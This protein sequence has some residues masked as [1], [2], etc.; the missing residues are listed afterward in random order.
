MYCLEDW[1]IHEQDGPFKVFIKAVTAAFNFTHHKGI[2]TLD[3]VYQ[4]TNL[5]VLNNSNTDLAELAETIEPDQSSRAVRRIEEKFHSWH[6]NNSDLCSIGYHGY[7][8]Q[9]SVFCNW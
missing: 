4:K 8:C 6:C 9:L 3:F 7:Q 1:M 2:Q 5:L